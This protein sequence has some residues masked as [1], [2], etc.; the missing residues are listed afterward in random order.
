MAANETYETSRLVPDHSLSEGPLKRSRQC[1]NQFWLFTFSIFAIIWISIAIHTISTGNIEKLI[2]PTDSEGRKC[3]IDLDV[4]DKPYL[5]FFDLTKCVNNRC[6]TTQVCQTKCPD[7][8]FVYQ[9]SS[10]DTVLPADVKN[11]LICQIDVNVDLIKDWST[12]DY[13][14]A[15][16]KCAKW[17]LKSKPIIKRCIPETPIPIEFN[18]TITNDQLNNATS[19]VLQ[20]ANFEKNLENIY[21]DVIATGYPILGFIGLS[22]VSAFLYIILLR[23]LAKPFVYATIIIICAFLVYLIYESSVQYSIQESSEWLYVLVLCIILLIVVVLSTIFLRKK[24]TLA[25]QLIKEA[26]KAVAC[27]WSSLFFPFVTWILHVI[28][29]VATASVLLYLWTMT[30][31]N[32]QVHVQEMVPNTCICPPTLNYTNNATCDP[33]IFKSEC[34]DANGGQ[35]VSAG[36]Y[37][38]SVT[39]PDRIYLYHTINF[40]AFL[41]LSFFVSAFEQMSLAAAFAAWY[42]TFNKHNVPTFTLVKSTW[43]S[44]RYH[45]GTLAFGS[46]IMWISDI[47]RIVTKPFTS[48]SNVLPNQPLLCLRAFADVIMSFLQYVNR[49][50]YIMCAIHGKNFCSSA[51]NAFKLITRNIVRVVV[52]TNVTD[53]LLRIANYFIVVITVGLTLGYYS[54]KEPGTIN[55]LKVPVVLAFLGSYLITSVFFKVHRAAVDTLF[56]CFL[57]DS[58]CNDG[59]VEKPFYMSMRLKQLLKK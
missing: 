24:I 57:E 25:C 13:Y 29:V 35:C 4:Q 6:D 59:S 52:I 18:S 28:V 17:Y 33:E 56:I 23:W 38:T 15:R 44:L 20:L 43:I 54:N 45:I 11:K 49:N 42:W 1:T 50:A 58:E 36:C 46:L 51:R 12:L 8:N 19:I 16:G 39:I 30:N 9:S 55:D 27:I 26:S 22:A 37:L 34:R 40:I 53:W 14:V 32:Y 2:V 41:W 10:N 3:G 7:S 21:H 5:V 31:P 48:D 47:I